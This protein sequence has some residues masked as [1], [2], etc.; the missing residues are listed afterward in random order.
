MIF[1]FLNYLK[2]FNS[3]MHQRRKI[4]LYVLK[5]NKSYPTTTLAVLL[6]HR[7]IQETPSPSGTEM[8][9]RNSLR[10]KTLT[11][12]TSLEIL[13]CQSIS[14]RDF[15]LCNQFHSESSRYVFSIYTTDSGR[16][17]SIFQIHYNQNHN[18]N[19]NRFFF[20]NV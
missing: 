13:F 20:S 15:F 1:I 8:E 5:T 2:Q 19:P 14:F 16:M 7:K 11:K 12:I 6:S 9:G 10:S 4:A 17:M 18:P 3:S